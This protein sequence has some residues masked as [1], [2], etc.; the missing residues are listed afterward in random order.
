MSYGSSFCG[1]FRG[2]HYHWIGSAAV[3]HGMSLGSM[4]V[5]LAC[6][7]TLIAPGLEYLNDHITVNASLRRKVSSR[8]VSF[9]TTLLKRRV[10]ETIRRRAF[11]VSSI[12]PFGIIVNVIWGSRLTDAMAPTT[13]ACGHEEA[14]LAY[15]GDLCLGSW[16]RRCVIVG[17]RRIGSSSAA[18]FWGNGGAGKGQNAMV[19]DVAPWE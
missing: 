2:L 6:I 18:K 14:N 7:N 8:A 5:L 4:T 1:L 3:G 10:K 12:N 17:D 19:C 9:D 15:L 16:A 13:A 11:P